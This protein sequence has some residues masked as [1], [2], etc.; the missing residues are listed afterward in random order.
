MDENL[1]TILLPLFKK[2]PVVYWPRKVN[3][4]RG[5]LFFATERSGTK[6]FQATFG[7]F[8]EALT[9]MGFD[10]AT[11]DYTDIDSDGR[12]RA[13]HRALKDVQL[14]GHR[15]FSILALHKGVRIAAEIASGIKKGKFFKNFFLVAPELPRKKSKR[16]ALLEATSRITT[17]LLIVAY[18]YPLNASSISKEYFQHFG[19]K[20]NSRRRGR[21]IILRCAGAPPGFRDVIPMKK[22]RE[23]LD[24]IKNFTEPA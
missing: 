22:M 24:C 13:I 21:R 5:T 4:K 20:V 14:I 19:K 23:I 3:E 18:K 1:P 11:L 10:V 12:I 9:Y 7:Q 16:K 8:T 15:P 17:D 2:T 6:S